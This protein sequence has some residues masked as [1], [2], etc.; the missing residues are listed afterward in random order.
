MNISRGYAARPRV[1]I[2][3]PVPLSK[4]LTIAIFFIK[5]IIRKTKWNL[6]KNNFIWI[7]NQFMII[8]EIE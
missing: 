8:E 1:D 7:E 3:Q 2:S 6:Q 5:N 4:L